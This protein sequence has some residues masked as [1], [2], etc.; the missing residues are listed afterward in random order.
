ML[1]VLLLTL[2][3]SS[4]ASVKGVFTKKPLVV[5][6][7]IYKGNLHC[8]TRGGSEFTRS[9]TPGDIV[10]G[11]YHWAEYQKGLSNERNK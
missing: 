11:K 5:C 9:I 7:N 8:F 3:I 4:C 1:A 6:I 2:I 10:M